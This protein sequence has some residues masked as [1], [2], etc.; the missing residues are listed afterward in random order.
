MSTHSSST[1]SEAA[2]K[3]L[4]A[5]YGVPFAAEHKVFTAAAAVEA[6]HQLG[7]PV[8]A[9]LGGDKIA[10]KTERGLVRLRLSDASAVEL[11]LIHI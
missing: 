10:H 11:S 9:K 7:Y 8:V 4:L 1:L 2:S 3:E 6:A 5:A